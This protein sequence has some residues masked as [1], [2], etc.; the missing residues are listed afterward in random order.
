MRLIVHPS[1]VWQVNFPRLRNTVVQDAVLNMLRV[2]AK[3]VQNSRIEMRRISDPIPDIAAMHVMDGAVCKDFA[4][5]A[6]GSHIKGNFV[7]TFS[8]VPIRRVP[9]LHVA[10]VFL[11]HLFIEASGVHPGGKHKVIDTASDF[12]LFPVWRA[13][14]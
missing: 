7:D 5:F 14:A 6:T 9:P 4:V 2:S 3:R 11:V 12:G 1:D 10:Q 13:L 8:L